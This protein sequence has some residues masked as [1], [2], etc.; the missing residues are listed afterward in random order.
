MV[1]WLGYES[2]VKSIKRIEFCNALVLIDFGRLKK[3]CTFAAMLICLTP[4]A[5]R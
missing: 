1:L 4:I 5:N 3:I 2:M